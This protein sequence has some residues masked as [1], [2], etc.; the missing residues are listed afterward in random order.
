M[1]IGIP[2]S[3]IPGA[4]GSQGAIRVKTYYAYI[5]GFYP[6]PFLPVSGGGP[7]GRAAPTFLNTVKLYI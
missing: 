7:L 3:E 2:C 6:F 1:R 5:I 4:V